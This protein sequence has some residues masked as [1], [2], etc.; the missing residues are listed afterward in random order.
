MR[1]VLIDSLTRL[2]ACVT[3]HLARNSL[4]HSESQ[5]RGGG[6]GIV[7]RGAGRTA[8]LFMERGTSNQAQTAMLKTVRQESTHRI[9]CLQVVA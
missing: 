4:K 5:V 2:F 8:C 9:P 3:K 7:V 6:I 1:Q